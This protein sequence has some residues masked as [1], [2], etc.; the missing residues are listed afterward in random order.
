M[1]QWQNINKINAGQLTIIFNGHWRGRMYNKDV[2]SMRLSIKYVF[3]LLHEISNDAQK[4][5]VCLM[6][7]KTPQWYC[8]LSFAADSMSLIANLNHHF[9][10]AN[11]I[12]M[13]SQSMRMKNLIR[14]P[15]SIPFTVSTKPLSAIFLN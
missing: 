12:E 15:N 14:F 7:I 4:M 10:C 3:R 11:A 9:I 1:A 8:P 2:C 13:I 6:P 5:N